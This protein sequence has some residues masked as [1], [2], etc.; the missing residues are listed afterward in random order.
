MQALNTDL[1]GDGSYEVKGDLTGG[2]ASVTFDYDYTGN[3]Q[4]AWAANTTYNTN[5]EYRY[6]SG[7]YRVIVAYTSGAT[8]TNILD[9]TNSVSILG[10]SVQLVT[11]GTNYSQYFTVGAT[12][13]S[14]QTTVIA[15]TNAPEAN[16]SGS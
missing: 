5:D 1:S 12:L 13:L 16:Y 6:G 11:I 14:A 15:S 9:G 7:W 3:T 10:P 2:P 8:R 4:A